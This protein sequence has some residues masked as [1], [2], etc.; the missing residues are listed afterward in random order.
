MTTYCATLDAYRGTLQT[1]RAAD[2]IW[3]GDAGSSVSFRC[4]DLEALVRVHGGAAVYRE[5]LYL[6]GG[7]GAR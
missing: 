6:R 4:T 2:M 1:A 7:H 5:S 3:P